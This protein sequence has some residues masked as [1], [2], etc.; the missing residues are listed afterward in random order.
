DQAGVDVLTNGGAWMGLPDVRRVVVLE[1][2]GQDDLGVAATAA[3]DCCVGDVD[4]GVGLPEV[5]EEHIQCR[6]LRTRSPPGQDL[7]VLG[8]TAATAWSALASRKQEREPHSHGGSTGAIQQSTS[9]FLTWPVGV[10]GASLVTH[11]QGPPP[12][13]L[14]QLVAS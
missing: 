12:A 4:T 8:G 2:R 5:V 14:P 9:S 11:A 1:A 7:Q 3:G 13:R 10:G 6:S